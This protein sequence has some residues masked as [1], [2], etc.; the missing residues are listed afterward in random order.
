ML[1]LK[2]AQTIL[3]VALATGREKGMKPLAVV[4]FDGRGAMKVA[5]AEDGTSLGR[6]KIAIGKAK[7][8]LELGVGSRALEKMA[9]ER[10][11][12]IVAATSA[13][14]GKLVPVAGGVLIR[15]AKG[16]VVGVVGVSGDTSDNDELAASAGIAAAGLV[17]DGGQG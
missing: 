11:H 9:K 16:V 1:T 12:F 3:K 15:D 2:K 10:A 17:A 7:G 6:M 4:V 5:A 8:A 14:G 13:V